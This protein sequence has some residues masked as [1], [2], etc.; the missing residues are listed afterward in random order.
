M[1][2]TSL[3]FNIVGRD[4]GASTTLRKVGREADRTKDRMD[5]LSESYLLARTGMSGMAVAATALGPA[6][7][8]VLAGATVAAGGL[9]SALVS[10]GAAMGVFGAVA[11]T[12][13]SKMTE[14]VESVRKAQ[15]KLE[16]AAT[17]KAKASATKELAKAQASLVGPVGAGAA[18]YIRLGDAWKAF[19]KA[20]ERPTFDILTRGMNLLA[21]AVPNL[22]PLFDAAAAAMSRFLRPIE[23]AVSGGGFD[24][25]VRF[26][27]GQAGPALDSF[28]RIARNTGKT[29]G[30]MLVAFA[31]T[32]Q[33]IL[34]GL[35]RMTAAMS[36][37]A[38]GPGMDK[39]IL[40]V[41]QNGPQVVAALADIARA[42]V[43]IAGALGPVGMVVLTIAGNL[44][45]LIA[46]APPG[47]ITGIAVAFITLSTA[48]KAVA[49]AGS[50]M[51]LAALAFN[52][53]GAA[54]AVAAVALGV[55][56]GKSAAAK[57]NV[58]GLTAA[59]I[60]DNGVMAANTR[61]HFVNAMQKD[62][63]LAAAAVSVSASRLPRTRRWATRTRN[64][65]SPTRW[66]TPRLPQIDCWPLNGRKA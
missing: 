16:K 18:A 1:A 12:S 38:N 34:Q 44:P 15:E 48:M 56:A 43:A 5:R 32:S 49:L 59:M 13:F 7:L 33:G 60:A 3:T 51:K 61:A 23:G 26:L 52:P 17:T 20:N 55:L 42:A 45:A 29:F 41:T 62:G 4:R 11:A 63:S 28:D 40:T 10:G 19:Q 53:W 31:P 37:W 21:K 24:R 65:R 66:T 46:A 54:V 35:E 14:S 36:K 27:A 9:S 57:A 47:M 64:G 25:F 39:F 6:L 58:Q 2:D 30:G 8:P 50:A 22:Q